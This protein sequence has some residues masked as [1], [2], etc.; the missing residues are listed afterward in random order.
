MSCL[1]DVGHTF[2]GPKDTKCSTISEWENNS[3]ECNDFIL[4]SSVGSNRQGV[5]DTNF[6]IDKT[7]QVN[8]TTFAAFKDWQSNRNIDELLTDDSVGLQNLLNVCKGVPYA[9]DLFLSQICRN[10]TI[11]D[12]KGGLSPSNQLNVTSQAKLKNLCGCY[13][14]NSITDVRNPCNSMCVGSIQ[15]QYNLDGSNIDCPQTICIVDLS[16]SLPGPEIIQQT[17]K[18]CTN[19]TCKIILPKEELNGVSIDT[20]SCEQKVCYS[21]EVPI[22]CPDYL[23]KSN[24]LW[25]V[26]IVVALLL[27]IFLIA[28][29]IWF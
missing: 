11:D 14:Y 28:I 23:K 13:A 9:C 16:D 21:G 8:Y 5:V 29:N 12:L 25:L 18:Q 10:C 19:C 26:I 4:A 17:C 6:N 2:P 15:N 3:I 22:K 24:N 7:E 27:F 20:S 1:V